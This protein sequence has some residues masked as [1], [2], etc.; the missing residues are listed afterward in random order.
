MSLLTLVHGDGEKSFDASTI[1]DNG[2]TNLK[3]SEWLGSIMII[4]LETTPANRFLGTDRGPK[5]TGEDPWIGVETSV[6]WTS[7]CPQKT[8][9]WSCFQRDYNGGTKM[10]TNGTDS[11][12]ILCS[13]LHKGVMIGPTPRG[14]FFLRERRL[15]VCEQY[16]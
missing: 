11:A 10:K 12:R 13:L 15:N 6:F 4:S 8:I 7:I 9:G 2:G 5:L 16:K 3:T 1:K 14:S